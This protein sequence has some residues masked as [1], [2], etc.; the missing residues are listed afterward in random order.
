MKEIGVVKYDSNTYTDRN[1]LLN[2]GLMDPAT[3][4]RGLTYLYGMESDRFPLLSLTQGQGAI[5]T[6]KIL[7]GGDTQ[8]TWDIIGRPRH[9]S[10]VRRLV[11]GSDTTPGKGYATIEVEFEDNWLI[12]QHTAVSPSGIQLRIQNDG[13]PTSTGSYIYRMTIMSGNSNTFVPVD[14]FIS[15]KAWG[16]SAPSI[17]ASKSDGNRSNNESPSKAIN[18]YG[19]YRFSKE[20]AGNMGN[21]VVN[22]QFDLEGGGTTNLWMPFEM[23][24]WELMRRFQLEEDLWYGEYN[25]DENGIIHL[26]DEETGEVVPHGAGVFEILKSV[27]NYETYSRLTRDRLDRII[28]RIFDNRIDSTF[29]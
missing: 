22:I 7:N 24:R 4:D 6:K 28:S 9:T 10:R 21:T 2:F 8:Y 13:I 26:K 27:G 1:M 19:Y 23:K 14:D 3:I 12:K 11:N 20:I 16:M 17:P 5:T 18:Q 29:D 25:R 15:G